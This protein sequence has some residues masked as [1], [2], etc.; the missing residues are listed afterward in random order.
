MT[1][2]VQ[3]YDSLSAEAYEMMLCV[4]WPTSGNAQSDPVQPHRKERGRG[5]TL[6]GPEARVVAAGLDNDGGEAVLRDCAVEGDPCRLT[7]TQG[8]SVWHGRGGRERERARARRAELD[9]DAQPGG[10]IDEP[11]ERARREGRVG[12]A[13]GDLLNVRRRV[14]HIHA[15]LW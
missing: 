1:H 10:Q 12:P 7:H 2:G 4:F 5:H 14:G 11:R 15:A 3:V 9:D 6:A 13:E 8:I